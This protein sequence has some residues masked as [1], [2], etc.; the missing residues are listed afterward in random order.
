LLLVGLAAIAAGSI[1]FAKRTVDERDRAEEDLARTSSTLDQVIAAAAG[2]ARL[3]GAPAAQAREEIFQ[4]AIKHYEE[5]IAKY[6]DDERM[7][8]EV[9]SAHLHLASLQAKTGSAE[10]VNSLSSGVRALNQMVKADF[11]EESYPGFQAIVLRIT[12]PTDWVAVKTP[13]LQTHAVTLYLAIQNAVSAYRDLS[14]KFPGSVPIRDDLVALLAS[15]AQLI[16]LVPER[17]GAALGSWV[18][19]S[20]VLETLVRDEPNN[21][22]YKRRLAEALENAARIQK[23]SDAEKDKAIINL[24]RAVELRQQLADA[25]PDD[26]TVQQQLARV[27]KDLAALEPDA[28]AEKGDA[29]KE[30]TKDA[31]QEAPA[32]AEPSKTEAAAPA[33]SPKAEEAPKKDSS[34]KDAEDSAAPATP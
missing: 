30:A 8:P 16:A 10:C 28:T 24:K 13:N 1:V 14:K 32:K 33:E 6:S 34:P 22:D 19:A 18:E 21:A 17:G 29:A 2:T 12:E 5:A 31:P 23:T 15:A 27:K 11:P 20:S 3:K 9:V 25:S 4:P 7:L 26:K